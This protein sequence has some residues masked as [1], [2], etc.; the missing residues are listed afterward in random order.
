MLVENLSNISVG[1]E[2]M[3]IGIAAEEAMHRFRDFDR[4]ALVHGRNPYGGA[5]YT[6]ALACSPAAALAAPAVIL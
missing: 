5:I 2:A 6:T 1:I 4:D 3:Q